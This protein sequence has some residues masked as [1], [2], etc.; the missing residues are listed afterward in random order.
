[1]I[2]A[3]PYASNGSMFG[4]YSCKKAGIGSPSIKI[5]LHSAFKV[6]LP[7]NGYFWGLYDPISHLH[8]CFAP[9]AQT[10]ITTW[11]DVKINI[12]YP[13]EPFLESLYGP[14]W[15]DPYKGWAWNREPFT[16]GS[17]KKTKT[18]STALRPPTAY[19]GL[20]KPTAAAASM[21]V[22]ASGTQFSQAHTKLGVTLPNSMSNVWW[23]GYDNSAVGRDLWPFRVV[24]KLGAN[25]Q[26]ASGDV[27]IVGRYGPCPK[28]R[29]AGFKGKVLYVN[30]ETVG[31]PVGKDFFQI[32]A[33]AGGRSNELQVYYA[34]MAIGRISQ[35][36]KI[37]AMKNLIG[38]RP[39]SSG[40]HFMLYL[41]SRCV[42]FREKIFDQIT[43][44][45]AARGRELPI[46]GGKCHG[47]VKKA[48]PNKAFVPKSKV[49]TTAS[50]S[51]AHYKFA[52]TVE[53]TVHDS[54]VTEKILTAFLGGSLPV[55]YGTSKVFELFNREAFIFYDPIHPELA[56][57]RIEFLDSN[58]QE[59]DAVMAKPI[60]ADGALKKYFSLSDAVGGGF[61]KRRILAMMG[62]TEVPT[63]VEAGD[64]RQQA[65]PN[66]HRGAAVLAGVSAATAL[67]WQAAAD[68]AVQY[69]IWRYGILKPTSGINRNERLLRL[70]QPLLANQFEIASNCIDL[71]ARWV[72]STSPAK[73]GKVSTAGKVIARK[74]Q[75]IMSE[76]DCIW[77]LTNAGVFQ[78]ARGDDMTDPDFDISYMCRAEPSLPYYECE[79]GRHACTAANFAATVATLKKRIRAAFPDNELADFKNG[80]MAVKASKAMPSPAGKIIDFAPSFVM[81]DSTYVNN[82]PFT[83]CA[84][85]YGGKGWPCTRFNITTIFPLQRCYVHGVVVPCAADVATY[86]SL[87]NQG[88]YVDDGHARCHGCSKCLLWGDADSGK[89]E[90]VSAKIG[91]MKRLDQCEHAQPRANAVGKGQFYLLWLRNNQ[92]EKLLTTE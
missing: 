40:K 14:K 63:E 45:S 72:Q 43:A 47:S 12:P 92:G 13:V 23:C 48:N 6:D 27:L 21:A 70:V 37:D 85:E 11:G 15:R 64:E 51:Y 5:D 81:G 42:A 52:I 8:P 9:V 84:E 10:V 2:F 73:R 88:E 55:Y 22:R 28:G 57:K 7:T 66:A 29:I 1:M 25:Q 49:W 60:F 62:E 78:L 75:A 3:S 69:K 18:S 65:V 17:C 38:D 31:E 58:P 35:L 33:V 19:N 41:S 82:G 24:Q 32:G 61:L 74:I 54:Y 44:A 86:S 39:R 87:D 34:S 71:P 56:L 36:E 50:K 89:K 30:G 67:T 79:P 91:A 68:E 26:G 83:T 59:Y 20:N 53:N 77:W 76:M 90:S 16:V 4:I 80:H 46:S